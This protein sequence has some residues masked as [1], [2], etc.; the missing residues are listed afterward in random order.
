MWFVMAVV[1]GAAQDPGENKD[2]CKKVLDAFHAACRNASDPSR[3]S[4]INELSHHVCSTSIG[5]ITPYLGAESEALRIAAAK[6]LGSMDHPKA[7][8]VLGAAVAPNEGTAT[9]FDAIAKA[10]QTLDWEAGA[11]PLH[12]VLAR[13]HQKGFLDPIHVV[14]PVLGKLGSSASVDPLLKLL[15]HCENESKGGGTGKTRSA[16]NKT[17]IALEGPIK[18]AL[19]QITGGNQPN[20]AKWKDWWRANQESLSA[21]ATIVYRCKLTGKRWSQ[22]A[23]EP[24]VCPNHSK[25]E[26]DGQV[27]KVLL[28]AKA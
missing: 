28:R 3:I 5:A 10:L 18:A 8:E 9:V 16:P 23:G 27:V 2:E 12:E 11:E 13:Y 20:Y 6:A 4:A 14:I 15:E 21:G 25:P 24:M 26:K 22:K 7:L 1:L 17:L 19:Q